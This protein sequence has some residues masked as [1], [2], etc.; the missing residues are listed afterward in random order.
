LS[1][2]VVAATIPFVAARLGP[3][4]GLLSGLL[5]A[6]NP[7]HIA[8]SVLGLR[9]E[10]GT[11]LF[12]A[13]I[14]I[15]FHRAPGAQWSWPVLAG[16]VAGA[17]VLT[18]SEVQPHL[19][20]MLAIGGWLI[21]RWSWRG[22]VVSWIVTIALVVPMYGGFY[23]RTGNPFFSANY[24]ATVNRNLE[25]QE[26]IGNDPGFPT[27]EE[28]QRDGWAAGPVITP[29]EY[30]FGYHSVPEFAAIS[31]RGYDHIFTR[32]LLAHDL[33]LLWL[34][35]LGTVLLLTTRQWIIPLVILWVLA[36][37]YSFLAGTGAPQIFPGRYA[38]HA[39]PYVTAVIAWSIIGPSRWLALRAWR[40]LRPRLALPGA[41][42]L[43]GGVQAP[44]GGGRV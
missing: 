35:M 39:L 36:P 34:F 11:L 32:V 30:F 40:R 10:L 15:L 27:E 1:V 18:R 21:A 12:L 29:M 9:E 19:L 25:F 22:I 6:I 28:Y 24:G 4:S 26:R 38:H 20:V 42:S 31:L 7:A 8:N 17:I 44:D 23:Y 43:Q 14:A 5:L 41:S 3:L 13:V 16:T 2:T 37:P 33:R